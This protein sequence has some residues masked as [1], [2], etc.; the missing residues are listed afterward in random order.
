MTMIMYYFYFA[1][2]VVGLA[3]QSSGA[4]A[5]AV[6]CQFDPNDNDA[7]VLPKHTFAT[8]VVTTRAYPDCE[9]ICSPSVAR[10]LV[11]RGFVSSPGQPQHPRPPIVRLQWKHG[12]PNF[13]HKTFPELYEF[14]H[15]IGLELHSTSSNGS[16]GDQFLVYH[17]AG[18]A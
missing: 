2:V 10:L 12:G 3:L 13:P 16:G 15:S 4:L 17:F 11:D 1:F 6:D 14:L 7:A 18:T 5:D 8:V 9:V